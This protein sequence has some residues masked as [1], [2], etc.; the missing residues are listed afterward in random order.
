MEIFKEIFGVIIQV[1]FWSFK[2]IF[3]VAWEYLPEL[4][5]LKDVLDYLSPMGMIAAVLGI[6]LGVISTVVWFFK[7]GG[8]IWNFIDRNLIDRRF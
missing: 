7:H 2:T 8:D 1:V 6:P 5:A 3:T 4:S